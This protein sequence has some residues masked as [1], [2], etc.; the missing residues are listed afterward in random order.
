MADR[1]RDA[2]DIDRHQSVKLCGTDL[3]ERR[4]RIDQC[5]IVNQQGRRTNGCCD[6]SYPG[7]NGIIQSDIDNGESMWGAEFLLQGCDV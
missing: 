7:S 6:I 2:A 3:P 5:G 1:V 4:I